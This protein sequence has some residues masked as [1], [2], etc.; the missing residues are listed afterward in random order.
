MFIITVTR[1]RLHPSRNSWLF[2][3]THQESSEEDF[4]HEL[5]NDAV[6]LKYVRLGAVQLDVS[7]SGYK[8]FRFSEFPVK[9]RQTLDV[10]LL[11]QRVEVERFLS[12]RFNSPPLGSSVFRPHQKS[13]KVLEKK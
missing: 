7:T 6:L 5:G 10:F 3:Q 9:W 4:Q 13:T 11:L 12:P 1:Y 8:I 2:F